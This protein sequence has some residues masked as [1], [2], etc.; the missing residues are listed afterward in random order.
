MGYLDGTSITVDAVLTKKGRQILS[1]GASSLN[2]TQF[3]LSDSGVDYTL[4]NADHASGSAYYGAEIEDTPMIEA[5]VHSQYSSRNR[6]VSLSRDTLSMPALE[7]NPEGA[8]TFNTATP[9]PFT[10]NV[11][12]FSAP[13]GSTGAGMQLLVPD[14]NIISTNG[15]AHDVTGNALSFIHEADTPQAKLFEQTGAGPYVWEITPA[16][17]LP[18]NGD[19]VGGVVNLTFIHIATGAHA[20]VSVTVNKEL[21]PTTRTMRGQGQG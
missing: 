12:A 13:V 8:Y 7:I 16:T 4:W 9:V 20:S 6:L 21:Q 3:T 15:T 11:L 19:G 17:N 14:T 5:N 1:S 18:D 10:V 2:V